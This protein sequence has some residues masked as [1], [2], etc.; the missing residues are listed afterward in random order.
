M[1]YQTLKTIYY[2]FFHTIIN[3]GIIAWGGACDNNIIMIQKA[4]NRILKIISKNKFI[5]N[6][7]MNLKQLFAS[8]SLLYNYNLLKNNFITSKS[9]T[10]N[11][12]IILSKTT[13]KAS[14]KSSYIMAIKVF[15]DLPNDLKIL[16][17][18]KVSNKIQL[19]K[20]ILGNL[21]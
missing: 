10:R 5:E 8:E 21:G 16:D 12:A 15:N 19:K 4:Q 7:P 6:K 9:I 20:W 2:A 14:D 13:L 3:Y 17:I 1:S 11:K 18:R